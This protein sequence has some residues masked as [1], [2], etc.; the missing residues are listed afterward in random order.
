MNIVAT[1]KHCADPLCKQLDFLPFTCEHCAGVYCLDHRDK[2]KCT[3]N[4]TEVKT[5]PKCP[6]CSQY[7][8]V[9]VESSVDGIVNDHILSGCKRH[10]LSKADHDRRAE[11]RKQKTCGV[12]GCHNE[13]TTKYDTLI[14]DICKGQYCLTHR[15]R[16]DH[17]CDKILK[18]KPI[19][20]NSATALL[21]KIRGNRDQSSA[22][23]QKREREMAR[24]ALRKANKAKAGTGGSLGFKGDDKIPQSQR[25][26]LEVRY[27]KKYGAKRY[28]NQSMFFDRKWTVG[29]V[30]DNACKHLKVENR[31][32][33]TSA[34]ELYLAKETRNTSEALQQGGGKASV[35]R[36]EFP[37]DIPLHLLEPSLMEGDTVRLAYRERTPN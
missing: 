3:L 30:I 32:N 25:F 33:I 35:V 9:P 10:L 37:T 21:A 20:N 12:P 34:L 31:N 11:I 36:T 2:H 18:D 6:V 7:I 14:C 16:D 26:Y 4:L 15:L 17:N 19:I 23:R 5:V 8:M 13:R 24:K 1:A 29:R 27:P 22:A 28:K